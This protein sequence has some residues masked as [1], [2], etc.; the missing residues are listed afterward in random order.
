MANGP[1]PLGRIIGHQNVNVRDVVLDNRDD[2]V[3]Y[4]IGDQIELSPYD[5]S[6]SAVP[7][8]R[9]GFAVVEKIDRMT[10]QLTVGANLSAGVP[11]A[12][13]GDYIYSSEAVK[14][15]QGRRLA[16]ARAQASAEA[17]AERCGCGVLAV[18]DAVFDGPNSRVVCTRCG[19]L[20]KAPPADPTIAPLRDPE[21]KAAPV[22]PYERA[23]GDA[24]I[25]A[26]YD[27]AG[28]SFGRA[29][30]F[31]ELMRQAHETLAKAERFQAER[32]VAIERLRFAIAEHG[33]KAGGA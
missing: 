16:A 18:L 20:A 27:V 14:G 6:E 25:A 17:K 23:R 19:R 28:A 24:L 11:G 32:A 4:G 29:G 2:V 5:L 1:K 33:R 9:P 15:W 26:M 12:A 8:V 13:S 3:N 31:D 10:G 7:F 21:P 30:D 22:D